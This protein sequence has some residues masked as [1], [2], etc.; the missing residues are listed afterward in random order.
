[1]LPT[2]AQSTTLH[3][4]NC[5]KQLVPTPKN[6]SRLTWGLVKKEPPCGPASLGFF[7][8]TD[9]KHHE[10]IQWLG[11]TLWI[12]VMDSI[13]WESV[14]L[15]VN[16]AHV[17]CVGWPCT[18]TEMAGCAHTRA[19]TPNAAWMHTPCWYL[20]HFTLPASSQL[21]LLRLLMLSS[22]TEALAPSWGV[23]WYCMWAR[24]SLQRLLMLQLAQIQ[25]GANVSSHAITSG[26]VLVSLTEFA[27]FKH[28]TY[29]S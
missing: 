5:P 12:H 10:P 1:M 21:Q 17:F 2:S 6:W 29:F 14:S 13:G 28:G 8:E 3:A 18:K 25:N 7:T 27:A 15:T 19:H 4:S 24:R 20:S 16:R 9:Q 22:C 11:P 26:F 23:Y